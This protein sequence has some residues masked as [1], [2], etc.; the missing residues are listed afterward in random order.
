MD[1]RARCS[2]RSAEGGVVRFIT[3]D[4]SLDRFT[5][6][7][8]AEIADTVDGAPS[9]ETGVAI[10]GPIVQD[11]LGLRLSAWTRTDGG[12]VNR[13]SW[14]TGE[15]TN[16]ANWQNTQAYKAALTLAPVDWLK[17]TP[18]IYY[19]YQHSND[20]SVFWRSLSDFGSGN[21]V[22]GNAVQLPYTDK[23]TLPS[24]KAQA[25]YGDLTVTGNLL[26]FRAH[27]YRRRRRDQ[28][29]IRFR[30]FCQCVF[31]HRTERL[32]ERTAEQ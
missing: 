25:V 17:I 14:E 27:Q 15:T 23:Y 7:A 6:Y 8:R 2:A 32:C 26:L 16:N 31:P 1:R 18:S 10:G 22:N 19:Q 4:P 24:I 30:W 21:F 28:F 13:Q 11:K 12:Y 5:G 29:R 20:T 3:P 9:Y